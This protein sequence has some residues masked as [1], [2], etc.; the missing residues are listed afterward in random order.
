[1]PTLQQLIK[2]GRIKKPVHSKSPALN[3]CPQKKGLCLKVY[4]RKPKKPNSANRSVADL[5]F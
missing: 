4:K 3:R 1:M 2:K 5:V